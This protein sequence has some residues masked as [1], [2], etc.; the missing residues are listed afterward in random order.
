RRQ[1]P[2]RRG[3]RSGERT[4]HGDDPL[5]P[6]PL[7]TLMRVLVVGGGGR[8]HA[9]L[10]KLRQ[11]ARVTALYCAP[12]NAGTAALAE[13]VAI[14]ADDVAAPV[15]GKADGR[16]AG[17]GVAVCAARA[18]AQAAIDTSMRRGAFGDAGRRVVIEEFL[19]GEEVSFMAVTD[20]DTVVP[21]AS[22]QDHKRLC[23]GDTGPN[24]GGM[25]AYSPSPLVTPALERAVME[26]IV[27]PVTATL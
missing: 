6:A 22:S 24:T 15:V 4:R 25:A 2:R 19:A 20:G 17:K 14:A 12:G 23:D 16:A 8:E 10:W 7:P 5:G 13:N 1:H 26:E 18:D 9:L 3:D 21:L 27:R 11:S